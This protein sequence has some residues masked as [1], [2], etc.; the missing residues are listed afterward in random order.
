M[1]AERD[2]QVTVAE[3]ALATLPS[4]DASVTSVVGESSTSVLGQAENLQAVLDNTIATAKSSPGLLS[5]PEQARSSAFSP[6]VE[7]MDGK[8]RTQ[9]RGGHECEAF[10]ASQVSIHD[11]AQMRQVIPFAEVETLRGQSLTTQV[12]P[13]DGP[14][15]AG[16]DHAPFNV[17][18]VAKES[19]FGVGVPSEPDYS[20]STLSPVSPLGV[21]ETAHLV[22][23]L[24]ESEL[25]VGIQSGEFGKIDIHTSLS[26]NQI[27]ARIYVEHDELGKAM[28]EAM[29]QLREKLSVDHRVDM[30]IELYSTG[31]SHSGG[32]DHQ[33]QRQH[34]TPDQNEPAFRDAL[35]VTPQVDSAPETIGSGMTAGLDMH[36]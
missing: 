17:N 28:T 20:Q 26:Q 5:V 8:T 21:V 14:P 18:A 4:Q 35:V 2:H 16:M 10:N 12:I 33:E 13:V 19:A 11:S 34:K 32:T 9:A 15:I 36:I 23:H 1:R 25:R 3:Y 6:R 7:S 31:S 27:S 22:Q 24:S 29:P 30:Q